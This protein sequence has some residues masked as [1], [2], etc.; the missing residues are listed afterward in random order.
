MHRILALFATSF[1]LCAAVPAT[2]QEPPA[3]SAPS[4]ETPAA[5]NL[6]AVK[7]RLH[8][9]FGVG[10]ASGEGTDDFATRLQFWWDVV[11]YLGLETEWI[12]A[13][14]DHGFNFALAPKIPFGNFT[15]LAKVGAFVLGTGAA[16]QASGDVANSYGAGFTY[17]FGGGPFGI[18]AEWTGIGDKAKVNVATFGGFLR[19]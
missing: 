9:G 3:Q 4:A 17:V 16:G 7:D 5:R 13:S 10:Y 2:A 15:A 18:R 1:F 11:P 8:A 19:W 6:I 12:A 14:G